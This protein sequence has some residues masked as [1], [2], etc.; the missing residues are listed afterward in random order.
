MFGLHVLRF[1]DI[2]FGTMCLLPCIYVLDAVRLVILLQSRCPHTR[3]FT[4]H[5]C[6]IYCLGSLQLVSTFY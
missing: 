2:H 4:V 5:H 6:P 1:E 3:I